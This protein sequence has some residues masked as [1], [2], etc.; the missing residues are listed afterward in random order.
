MYS[1]SC[2]PADP[3]GYFTGDADLLIGEV[4][5]GFLISGIF[6]VGETEDRAL[7]AAVG[8]YRD[9]VGLSL[10]SGTVLRGIFG[11][12]LHEDVSDSV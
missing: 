6:F 5:V 4:V 3:R 11:E 10:G 12:L 9:L 1:E 7:E 2:S 8:A